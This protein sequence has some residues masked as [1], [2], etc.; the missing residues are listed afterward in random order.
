MTPVYDSSITLQG[1]SAATNPI[2]P[3]LMTAPTF[4]RPGQAAPATYCA[5]GGSVFS[6]MSRAR[7][8]RY[9]RSAASYWPALVYE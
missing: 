9:A 6:P 1:T 3:A 7:R 8:C 5:P 2:T 4:F